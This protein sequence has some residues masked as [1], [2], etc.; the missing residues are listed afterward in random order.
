MCNSNYCDLCDS[1]C[2][3]TQ[4]VEDGN[5]C[6]DCFGLVQQGYRGYFEF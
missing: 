2:K 4:E 6:K 3:Y 1:R 5:L